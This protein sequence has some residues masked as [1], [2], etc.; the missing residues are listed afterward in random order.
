[1]TRPLPLRIMVAFGAIEI[2]GALMGAAGI[3][4][5]IAY[6]AHIG[7]VLIT[8]GAWVG[9]VGAGLFAKV[10]VGTRS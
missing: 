2:V 1:M 8:A 6:E 4:I 5:E 9:A 10:W 3:G 7:F